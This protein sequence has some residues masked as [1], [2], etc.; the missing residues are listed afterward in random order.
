V[1]LDVAMIYRERGLPE[2]SLTTIH[3][4]LD[5]YS[6][7]S[8]PQSVLMLE[9]VVL[10][11]LGRSQQACEALAIAIGRGQPTAD[12]LFHLAQ[13]Y[14]AAGRHE[15]AM[16]TAQQALALNAS[17]EPSRQLLMQLAART[18]PDGVLRR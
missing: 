9:G 8:E 5:T 16:A 18:S 7:G 10:L 12:G 11:E 2:R 15:Q 3:H 13:A 6:P 17:H 1:L 4:L 14:S